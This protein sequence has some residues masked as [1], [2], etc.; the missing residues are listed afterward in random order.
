MLILTNGQIQYDNNVLENQ[1]FLNETSSKMHDT[2]LFNFVMINKKD[3]ILIKKFRIN[4]KDEK[5]PLKYSDFIIEKVNCDTKKHQEGI[6]LN[7]DK[8]EALYYSSSGF[9]TNHTYD[10]KI[11]DLIVKDFIKKSNQEKLLFLERQTE[12]NIENR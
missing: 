7:C 6:M 3:S 5:S 1:V 2:F 9:E 4:F 10:K 11:Y 12:Y 8:V